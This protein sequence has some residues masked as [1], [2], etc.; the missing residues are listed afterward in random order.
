MRGPIFTLV[1]NCLIGIILLTITIFVGVW[2]PY[3]VGKITLLLV[4]NPISAIKLPLRLIFKLI[5]I[6]QDLAL[7]FFGGMYYTFIKGISIIVQL[8]GKKDFLAEKNSGI[9]GLGAVD[10]VLYAGSALERIIGDFINICAPDADNLPTFSA[11]AHES[12]I[13]LR[14]SL[15]S[16][17]DFSSWVMIAREIIS[18]LGIYG[19]MWLG[20]TN[21]FALLSTALLASAKWLIHLPA[22]LAKPET[23]VITLSSPPRQAA[24]DLALSHWDAIDRTYAILAGY[25][26]FI[27]LGAA[28]ISKG[29]PISTSE[30]GKQWEALIKI[31]RAHV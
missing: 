5:S 25:G 1:Q 4:A 10:A 27:S 29:S 31:G 18:E 24:L 3:I 26:T 6:M 12:L 16:M 15:S 22:L 20:L 13:Y 28:Y 17:L 11:A 2:I 14:S 9:V 8:F 19:A 7:I 23:W 30:S 21:F